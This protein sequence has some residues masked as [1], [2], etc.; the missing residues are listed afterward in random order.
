MNTTT[1]ATRRRLSSPGSRL[2]ARRDPDRAPVCRQSGVTLVEL[3]VAISIMTIVGGM[4]ITTW[5]ALQSSYAYTSK[6]ARAQ[7]T[8]R[9]TMGRMV[10]EIRD[11]QGQPTGAQFA[12]LPPIQYAA[13]DEIRFTTAF[14]D[15]GTGAGRILLVRYWYDPA[16]EKIIR[17]RDTNQ[18]GAFD[19]G[20]RQDVM[21]SNVVNGKVPST[22]DPTPLF[23]YQYLDAGGNVQTASAVADTSKIRTVEIHI[24]ADLD[25]GR[26]PQYMDLIS[27]A[28]PRNQRQI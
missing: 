19:E 27:T 15:P 7:E 10:R 13:A 25:P 9:D 17:Q 11:A 26:S 24:I 18:S 14:N 8:A 23:S 6:S 20:D 21:A 4:I 3:L 28:Q 12:G 2:A 1:H 16:Q 5:W 22:G